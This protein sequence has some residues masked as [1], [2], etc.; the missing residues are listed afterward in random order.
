MCSS[1]LARTASICSRV[2]GATIEN[3]MSRIEEAGKRDWRADLARLG[4]IDP[5][6]FAPHQASNTNNNTQ[7]NILAGDL[8]RTKQLIAMFAGQARAQV[9]SQPEQAKLPPA[10]PDDKPIDV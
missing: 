10:G 2:R 9:A 7:V 3:A 6:R 5:A 4:L 8:E 1:D